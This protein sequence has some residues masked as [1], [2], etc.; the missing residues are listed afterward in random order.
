MSSMK[1]LLAITL[2]SLGVS[3]ANAASL[4]ALDTAGNTLDADYSDDGRVEFDLSVLNT[5]LMRFRITIQSEDNLNA[6]TGLPQ[7]FMSFN[8]VVQSFLPS[9]MQYLQFNFFGLD[10]QSGTAKDQFSNAFGNVVESPSNVFTVFMGAPVFTTMNIGNP[11]LSNNEINWGLSTTGFAAGQTYDFTIQAI[12]EPSEIAMM[13][14]GL[15][16]VGAMVRRRSSSAGRA[17]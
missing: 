15:G 4:T 5:N 12:P 11:L 14:A 9:G 1:K 8:S 6:A 16:M 13:L 10:A 2:A 17:A 3:A 7:A